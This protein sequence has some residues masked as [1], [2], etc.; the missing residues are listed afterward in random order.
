MI[1]AAE[2]GDRSHRGDGESLRGENVRR[3]IGRSGVRPDPVRTLREEQ[4]S[5]AA[6]MPKLS[7][8]GVVN[9]RRATAS[10]EVRL[11]G[12]EQSPVDETPGALPG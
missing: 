11:P 1:D 5:E 10:R 3:A 6:R 8:A 2:A 7:G 12:E 4:G 9:G